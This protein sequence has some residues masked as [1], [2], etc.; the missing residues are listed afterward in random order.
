[1]RRGVFFFFHFY[2]K[3]GFCF[4]SFYNII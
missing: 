1:V 3:L 2:L 4:V